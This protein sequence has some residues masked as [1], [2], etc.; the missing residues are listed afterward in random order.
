MS[1]SPDVALSGAVRAAIDIRR[2]P[3]IRPLVGA[4][5]YDFASVATM[6]AGNPANTE[7][8]RRAL[9][10]VQQA[11]RDREAIVRLLDRQLE[12]RGAPAEARRAAAELA[13]PGAVAVVT[14]QQAGLFGGPLYTLLKA[15]TAIQLAARLREAYGAPAV[16][17]FWVDEEDHDW[18]EIRSADV[19]D[20]N[21]T[22]QRITLPDVPGARTQMVSRL[23]LDAGIEQAISDLERLMA[24][25]EYTAEVI[26]ALR[27]HYRPG[28][29]M[30]TAFAGW[31]ESLLGR[32][33]LVVFQAADPAAKPIVADLF[34]REL[35]HPGRTASLARDAGAELM[36]LGH[37]PQ[38]EPA[39]DSLALFYIDDAGRLPIKS[40]GGGD[41]LVGDSAQS[42][43][44]LIDRARATPEHFSP[45]VLLRP[46]V[47]DRLFPTICY[48][49]GPSELA[50]QAQLRDIYPAFGV[51]APLLYSRAS[52][53]LLDSGA[54]RFLDRHR[55]PLEALHAQD[56]STLN[57][58]LESQLPP[59]L[60]RALE[61][62]ARGISNGAAA[63]KAEVRGLDPT[64]AG[65]VD[66]TAE[67][68]Q[69]E[70]KTLHHKIIQA[71]KRKDDTLRRQLERT[72]N[73]AFPGGH[74]Q[75]R[76]LNIVF[77][78]NRYGL[79]LTDRLVEHLPLETGKH[80]VLT[81]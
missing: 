23:A 10:R 52:A 21:L 79:A 35:E 54:A 40:R 65:A 43:Q 61:D 75:E 62:A 16:P 60:E 31:I 33:G 53:T 55:L 9:T 6:F 46:L 32:H 66:T 51:E 77:A 47:Q 76:S 70:L 7:D 78:L 56:D 8:W 72:R 74:P 3:W 24:K 13:D 42:C 15:V 58:V 37:H 30:A 81:L 39:E 80:Y 50:Y 17:V 29:G 27:R 4:Y 41:C 67:H 49:G 20:V 2:L 71:A 5:V 1:F 45:N 64:L 73:L 18:D 12:Q 25:S 19:L 36:R 44:S 26:G 34:V 63:F 38:V 57:R 22:P 68:M 14:G 28:A 59:S 48:V 69:R 11:P